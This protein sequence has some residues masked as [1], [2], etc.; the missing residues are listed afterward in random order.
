MSLNKLEKSTT[1][2]HYLVLKIIYF[3]MTLYH[4]QGYSIIDLQK[5]QM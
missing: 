2:V 1:S 4:H 5:I 3:Q